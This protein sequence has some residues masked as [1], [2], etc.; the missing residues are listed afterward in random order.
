MLLCCY[1]GMGYTMK[2]R[3]RER[4]RDEETFDANGKDQVNGAP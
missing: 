1:G 3:E 4:G 2:E